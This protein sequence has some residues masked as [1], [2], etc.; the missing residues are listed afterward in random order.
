MN[1]CIFPGSFDPV[2]L[3]HMDIVCR[4]RALFG[5]VVI[6]VLHNPD[7]TGCFPV[8]T[9][10]EMLKRACAG[11]PDVEI[12]AFSGLLVDFARQTNVFT[13]VRGVRGAADLESESLMAR[14]NRAMCPELDTVLL[15]ASMAQSGVSASLVRQIAS[16]RGDVSPFV[17]EA[18][19]PVIQAHFK[20]V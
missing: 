17:P 14:A 15:P 6:G 19:L 1:G 4:A 8:D 16:L 12:I 3:G 9:R 5:R 10:V 2:T 13:I 18:A 11:M 7:K 20:E